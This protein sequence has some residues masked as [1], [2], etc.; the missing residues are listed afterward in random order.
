MVCFL[1]MTEDSDVFSWRILSVSTTR[2]F[3]NS[4][5]LLLKF[6]AKSATR[7]SF[8]SIARLSEWSPK[9][10]WRKSRVSLWNVPLFAIS[11]YISRTFTPKVSVKYP[12]AQSFLAKVLFVRCRET[13]RII[14]T[15]TSIF[16]LKTTKSFSNSKIYSARSIKYSLKKKKLRLNWPINK[17]V[18]AIIALFIQFSLYL[19][20]D[21]IFIES[22]TS[23]KIITWNYIWK[24][25]KKK[26]FSSCNFRHWRYPKLLKIRRKMKIR[27]IL[28]GWMAP[29]KLG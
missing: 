26:Y 22:S 15:L 3:E 18:I 21:M 20:L 11:F 16:Y 27:Y 24:K 8:L 29:E 1:R 9:N 17:A 10:C 13:H 4:A 28:S 2:S 25:K 7:K 19:I 5:L 12:S 23:S 6:W 14:L